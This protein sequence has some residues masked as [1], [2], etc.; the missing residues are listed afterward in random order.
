MTPLLS[1]HP[2][3]PRCSAVQQQCPC[4]GRQ[5][6]GAASSGY[7]SLC[8]HADGSYS[9]PLGSGVTPW[10]RNAVASPPA[11][12]QCWFVIPAV[13]SLGAARSRVT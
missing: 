7:S 1:E 10:G 3:V 6:D 5:W 12:M 13:S 8:A 4:E 9:L 2:S 11:V